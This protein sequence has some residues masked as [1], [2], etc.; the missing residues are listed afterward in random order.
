M[1]WVIPRGSYFTKQFSTNI[2]LLSGSHQRV[3]QTHQEMTGTKSHDVHMIS[4]H[5]CS[6]G[7]VK[8][9]TGTQSMTFTVSHKTHIV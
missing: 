1:L 2:D 9:H 3:H 4:H 7:H 8:T 6:H 5:S